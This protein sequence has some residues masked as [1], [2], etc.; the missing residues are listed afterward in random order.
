MR[1]KKDGGQSVDDTDLLTIKDGEKTCI[2]P[3]ILYY[4]KKMPAYLPTN[5]NSQH[6]MVNEAQ[7]LISGV[8][9][10]PQSNIQIFDLSNLTN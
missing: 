4:C 7:T 1:T 8:I 5:I 10:G 6:G 3:N 9:P 2:R